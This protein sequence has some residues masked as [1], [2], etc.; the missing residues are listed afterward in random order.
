MMASRKNV[1]QVLMSLAL[2]VAVLA[3]AVQA[4]DSA[5]AP[6]PGCMSNEYL[7]GD[8]CTACVSRRPTASL[9]TFGGGTCRNPTGRGNSCAPGKLYRVIIVSIA[10]PLGSSSCIS[11]APFAYQG[12]T[13]S[14]GGGNV[15]VNLLLPSKGYF[16]L[17]A[18]TINSYKISSMT[19]AGIPAEMTPKKAITAKGDARLRVTFKDTMGILKTMQGTS[20]SLTGVMQ[21]PGSLLDL[22]FIAKLKVC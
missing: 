7:L 15:A 12:A 4:L 11:S 22:C 5:E 3:V 2:A 6:A 16:T 18:L 17:S 20:V 14:I 21:R 8:K 19:L 9:S 1:S 13:N 10:D